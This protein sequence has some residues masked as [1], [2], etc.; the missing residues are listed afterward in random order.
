MTL[1]ELSALAWV[2]L[3]VG[4]LSVG[5]S[6]TALPGSNTLGVALFAAA[7]PA[8]ASTGTLLV[9]LI[10]GDVIALLLYRHHARV[11]ALLPL[12]PAVI[13]GLVAGSAF[14]AVADD[15]VTRRIIGAILLV[16]IAITL[17]RRRRTRDDAPPGGRLMAASYGAMG[18]FTTM[19]ANA[20]G[21]VMTM[22]FVAMRLPMKEF[23]GTAAWF[24][25]SVNLV[26]LPFS[27]GLGLLTTDALLLDLVLVPTVLAGAGIGWLLVRRMNQ[28]VFT[29][30]VTVLTVVGAIYLMI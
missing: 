1:P 6:K 16:L 26:K 25:A 7:L 10:L 4:G 30:A 3:A 14:L 29:A 2:A 27:I 9:L 19:V 22:Y 28:R 11:R 5:I 15:V 21:P 13:V 24:F 8:K 23:L 17:W 20:G 18:G 12:I